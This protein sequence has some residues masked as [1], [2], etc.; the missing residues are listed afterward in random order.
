MPVNLSIKDVPDSVAAGLRA[1]AASNH[2]SLQRELMAIVEV[3]ASTPDAFRTNGA[4]MNVAA[5]GQGHVGTAKRLR[6]IEEIAEELRKVFPHPGTRGP[7]PRRSFATCGMVVTGFHPLGRRE[8]GAR[9]DRW[10]P[11]SSPSRPRAGPRDRSS[12]S[13]SSALTSMCHRPSESASP[14]AS[15]RTM[16]PTWGRR[17]SPRTDRDVRRAR[18]GFGKVVPFAIGHVGMT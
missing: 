12:S 18:R 16:P 2:R 1:R 17:P 11:F 3:A 15:L 4:S 13:I 14:S 5:R 9:S 8:N 7:R 6:P 10:E